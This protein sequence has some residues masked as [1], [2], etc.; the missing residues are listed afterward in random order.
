MLIISLGLIFVV[1]FLLLRG[2][3]LSSK[4]RAIRSDREGVD[5]RKKLPCIL[6]GSP[7]TGRERIHST[8]FKGERDSIVH[9]YGCP[10]CYGDLATEVRICPICGKRLPEGGYLM[11]RMWDK[12]RGKRHLHVS[13]CT[14]CRPGSMSD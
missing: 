12:K 1:L 14:L 11:G 2:Y 5:G 7:L 10:H 9:L 8:A 13:G 3:F 6:C 4:S